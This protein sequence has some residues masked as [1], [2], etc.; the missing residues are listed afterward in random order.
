MERYWVYVLKNP[1]G[2]VYVGM[3]NNLER[4]MCQHDEGCSSTKVIG[5][6]WTLHHSWSNLSKV[7]ASRLERWLQ[8]RPKSVLKIIEEHSSYDAWLQFQSADV[9]SY[10]RE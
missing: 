7:E 4:R 10:A 8:R 5:P 2:T 3:T 9:R 6:V 1:V